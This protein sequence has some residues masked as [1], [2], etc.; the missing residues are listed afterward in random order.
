MV[1]QCSMV[2]Y[3][4]QNWDDGS[5]THLTRFKIPH[6]RHIN[7]SSIIVNIVSGQD[8]VST[9]YNQIYQHVGSMQC[10]R[11]LN[12]T[13]HVG[14]NSKYIKTFYIFLDANTTRSYFL[15]IF[16]RNLKLL[17]ASYLHD[18]NMYYSTINVGIWLIL[19]IAPR[20]GIDG[21][22]Y[23]LSEAG[24]YDKISEHEVLHDIELIIVIEAKD[25]TR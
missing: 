23:Y 7:L 14:C 2:L 3:R 5:K 20:S 25:L 12:T 19:P 17:Y 21:V 6:S 22:L 8:A 16:L 11:L 10:V 15:V 4:I 13:S 24:D 18:I 9:I 1:S